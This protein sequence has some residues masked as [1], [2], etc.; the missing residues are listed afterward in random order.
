MTNFQGQKTSSRLHWLTPE[1][2]LFFV[3]VVTS[4]GL[5]VALLALGV[6][7]IWRLVR[8]RQVVVED[9][10]IKR[11]ELPMLERDLLKQEALK[12]QL[13]DQEKRLLR[14]LAGTNDLDTFLAGL[15]LL[16]LKNAVTLVTTVPGEIERFV[17]LKE[18]KDGKN[19]DSGRKAN[20]TLSSDDSLLREGLE[21]RSALITVQGDFRNVQG[22]LQ[23]LESLDVFV[24]T[25]DLS[26]KAI[27]S[28]GQ[29]STGEELVNTELA[30][31][32]SAYGR[33]TQEAGDNTNSDDEVLP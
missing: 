11:L 23:D 8:E 15:N 17:S 26:M 1:R 24:I 4:V 7:P 19:R 13:E 9:L 18:A 20:N 14:M 16:A 12:V 32:L 21:K 28:R 27:R 5:A 2:A 22:F 33:A 29:A 6:V 3:P 25:S 10:S 30:L 31:Q